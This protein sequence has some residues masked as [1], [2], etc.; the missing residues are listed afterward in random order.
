MSGNSGTRDG[1]AGDWEHGA[2]GAVRG[3]KFERRAK[4]GANGEGKA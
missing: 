2:A 4:I 3:V 1:T